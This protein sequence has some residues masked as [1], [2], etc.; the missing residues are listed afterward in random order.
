MVRRISYHYRRPGRGET[1]FEE[2]L[3]LDRPDVKVTL[4]N[5]YEG[6]GVR[7]GTEVILEAGAPIVWFVFPGAWHNVGRFHLADGTFT[8]W[9]T[10]LCTPV[11][12][13]AGRWAGTDLFLDL[14][15]PA[16]G[17]PPLWLDEDEFRRAVA[18]AV[19]DDAL[20]ARAL[21]ERDAIAARLPRGAWPPF[22][23]RELDLGR[24][25]TL[26]ATE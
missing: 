2:T 13:G 21:E 26:S 16:T 12:L 7:A 19:L 4:L 1:V 20:A 18:S 9:Y 6:R 5:A 15:Q 25:R 10:N 22:V 17:S 11:Q 23:T 14:W 3:V 24:A 8:G